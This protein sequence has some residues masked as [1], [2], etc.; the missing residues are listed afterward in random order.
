MSVGAYGATL[1]S[2]Y[3][4][5]PRAPEVLV[6]GNRYAVVRER[7]THDDLV[8]RERPDAPFRECDVAVPDREMR[9]TP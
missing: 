2:N 9:K 8:R 7:E 1:A 4:D 6:D 5:R 3:N